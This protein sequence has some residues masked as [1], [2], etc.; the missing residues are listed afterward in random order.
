MRA[1]SEIGICEYRA[2]VRLRRQLGYRRALDVW[3]YTQAL[4][5]RLG[6]GSGGFTVT[7]HAGRVTKVALDVR[8]LH[9]EVPM[10]WPDLMIATRMQRLLRGSRLKYGV[11]SVEI[12][13]GRVKWIAPSPHVRGER[14][15]WIDL[16]WLF[17]H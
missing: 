10:A 17:A 13:N 4:V 16:G 9:R 1:E 12:S 15:E 11:L 7:L 2:P 6:I 14:D 3:T 5:E 8:R